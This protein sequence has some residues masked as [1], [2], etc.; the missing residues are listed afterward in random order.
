MEKAQRRGFSPSLE[1]WGS[2]PGTARGLLLEGALNRLTGWQ[3]LSGHRKGTRQDEEKERWPWSSHRRV[4]CGWKHQIPECHSWE[5][6]ERG[7]SQEAPWWVTLSWVTQ[8]RAR[9]GAWVSSLP[10]QGSPL[11]ELTTSSPTLSL[12][13][14][15]LLPPSTAVWSQDLSR[16][17]SL[18]L[19][20][21]ST[22]KGEA[23]LRGVAEQGLLARGGLNCSPAR[24]PTF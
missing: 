24:F 15:G 10:A 14:P 21:P 9:P 16:S 12:P 19:Q 22:G 5:G 23:R 1:G 18:T 6:P 20:L 13:S 11:Q 8:G 4:P 7:S 2:D 3:S 17:R